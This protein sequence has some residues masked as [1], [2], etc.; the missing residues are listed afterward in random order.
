MSKAKPK[1]KLKVKR[2]P[3]RSICVVACCLVLVGAWLFVA[4]SHR[5]AVA[6]SFQ[7]ASR[8]GHLVRP[9]A[10]A[11]SSKEP[12][13]P[14]P[15]SV[16]LDPR[17]VLLGNR[18]F[19]E[20]QLSSDNQLSCASCHRSDSGGADALP[21]SV[22]RANQ[23]LDLNAPTV[24]NSSLNFRQFWDGRADTLEEQIDG[25]IHHPEELN[26]NWP[27]IIAKLKKNDSYVS[28][29]Q[30]LYTDGIQPESIRA[31][32]ATYERSL[33]T[34]NA[35]FDQYLRGNQLAITAAEKTGYD[36]FKSYG[37][38]ACH[39]GTN[40]GGNMFQRL[41]IMADYFADRGNIQPADLGR[42]NI[43]ERLRDRYVFKVPS[44]RNIE[45]TAPY[46]HD[47]SVK[48]LE[49]TVSI[50]AEYQLGREILA[51]DVSLIVQFLRTLT[52]ELEA[53]A[54]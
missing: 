1:V 52:G 50:M 27:E 8:R 4:L 15:I 16:D 10:L 14:I 45:L 33:I 2:Q 6:N 11:T 24:W 43:T 35:R 23:Q 41:G 18:L 53:E 30:Q 32:I 40:V 44:L 38:I 31:A 26:S 19:H 13:T 47:G 20:T 51:D 29:F 22:G 7:L 28:A 39:Q 37:C 21:R 25:P 54:R 46:L 17:Q 42:I 3:V 36:L 48:T 9:A 5:P 12:I 34:P 49:E